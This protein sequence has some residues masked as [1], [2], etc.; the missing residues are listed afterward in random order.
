LTKK[1]MVII[2][3]LMDSVPASALEGKEMDTLVLTWHQR[4]WPRGKLT[5]R[6]SREI[7]LALPTGTVL[8]PGIPLW[9]ESNWCLTVLACPEPVLAIQ[10]ADWA[11]AVQAAFEIGNRHFPLAIEGSA[12]LVPDDP[13]M[14]QLFERME[15]SFTRR[16]VPF[17]PQGI[18]HS[19]AKA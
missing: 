5:T 4:R 16:S 13:A 10:P 7:A 15:I 1:A 8:Q 3:H 12:L 19:H 17:N 2:D 11:T 14:V 6:N 9:V 18:G